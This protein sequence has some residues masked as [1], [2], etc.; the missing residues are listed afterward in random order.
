MLKITNSR[1]ADLLIG[2]QN[3]HTSFAGQFSTSRPY[4]FN[5]D[6]T[7]CVC[8]AKLMPTWKNFY[9]I[10][11]WDANTVGL[12]ASFLGVAVFFL[13]TTFEQKSADVWTSAISV[14]SMIILFLADFFPKRTITRFYLGWFSLGVLI[15]TNTFLAFY[16]GFMLHPLHEKQ[17]DTFAQIG[18]NNL[19]LGSDDN[20][21]NYLI[22]QN[23][24]IQC[25]VWNLLGAQFSTRNIFSYRRPKLN[26]L[27]RAKIHLTVSTG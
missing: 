9:Y 12:V 2:G 14:F 5:D 8:R 15:S 24:V 7:W 6:L 11:T 26:R 18:D 13:L 27:S 21:R 19:V 1:E 16:Y 3:N 25:F 4:F 23:Q 20:M 22:E 10:V 17:I